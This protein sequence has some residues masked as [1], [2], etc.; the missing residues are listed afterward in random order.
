MLYRHRTFL[1]ATTPTRESYR[2]A[3]ESKNQL[4]PFNIDT[5]NRQKILKNGLP[6]K[7]GTF[8]GSGGFGTVYKV[9]Y[10]GKTYFS[11][12][13]QINCYNSIY[14]TCHVFDR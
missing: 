13:A 6:T 7:I 1:T 14:L 2:K 4:S 9:L 11:W 8:L 10:K 5:P 12:F 3:V